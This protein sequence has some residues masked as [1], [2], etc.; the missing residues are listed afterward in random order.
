MI[1][2]SF[3][4]ELISLEES[5]NTRP[6]DSPELIIKR[7]REGFKNRI[8]SWTEDEK[9]ELETDKFDSDDPLQN[10][11]K[12]CSEMPHY[13]IKGE[14]KEYIDK[15][16]I[17]VGFDESSN[18]FPGTYGKLASFKFGECHVSLKNGKYEKN[19]I[20]YKPLL[21]YIED[22]L[23][24]LTIYKQVIKKFISRLKMDF[25]IDSLKYNIDDL[26]QWFETTYKKKIDTNI[27]GYNYYYPSI[28]H[29]IDRIRT[30]D[31]IL[32]SMIRIKEISDWGKNKNIVFLGDGI[33][34]FRQH[35]FPPTSF[36]ELFY[37]FLQ[38]YD[39][40]YFSISKQSRLRDSQGNFIL[41]YW[42]SIIENE[43]FLVEL[44]D[45]SKYTK[46]WTYITRFVKDSPALRFDIPDFYNTKEAITILQNLIPFSPR[47]YPLC[48]FGAHQASTL[49]PI[50]YS[51]FE[52]KF[53]ELQY[54]PNT[55]KFM[56]VRRHKIIPPS[57]KG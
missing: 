57:I 16:Y 15:D 34:M 11:G 32:K 51:N 1:E 45:L 29:V 38:T 30:A 41:L 9:V 55:K 37:N 44:P 14:L 19:L 42:D 4:F 40:K 3:D 56:L 31:E 5:I 12:L 13:L 27:K 23:H 25:Y 10:A 24:K 20:M 52:S 48:L 43:P 28:G 26:E 54:D 18:T 49:L 47:G 7:F 33:H 46:S 21:A 22:N 2:I 36:V 39:I 50:E 17:L 6:K 8:T 35:I 53:L